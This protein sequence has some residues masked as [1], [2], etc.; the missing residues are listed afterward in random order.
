M[1]RKIFTWQFIYNSLQQHVGVILLYVLESK[2]SSPGRQGF[3]MAVNE[4][5]E[6]SGSIGGGIMEHKFAEM[7]KAKLQQSATVHSLY[8]QVHDKLAA[9]NHS[10][11]ICSGEQT[12]F[13]Y[14]LQQKDSTHISAMI[15]SLQQ[16]QNGTLQLSAE[17]IIFSSNI[18]EDNFYFN[19]KS[20]T[21]F[22]YRE[23]TGCHNQLHI[24]GG[25]HCSLALSQLMSRMDFYVHVYDER[26]GLNTT[27]ENN[28]AHNI[29]LVPG[30]EN[31]Q[32]YIPPGN[33]QYVVIMTVGY[34]TDAVALKSLLQNE[35]AYLGMLGSKNK[36][37]KL[38]D[39]LWNE[40]IDKAML[41]R[42]HAPIGIPIKSQTTEEIAVSIA[43]EI[44]KVKNER[45]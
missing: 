40:V 2:G 22:L 19:K 25:G 15:E 36:M 34:R 12:I 42:I 24:I 31:M 21:E 7:A 37:A 6:I 20:E 45:L 14:S 8:L 1:Q 38:F 29:T 4:H 39:D 13:I 3:F 32:A 30:Y 41:D 33:N 28:F 43:A 5:G 44:I 10:G 27:A 35:F 9:A 23:K 11:M 18:P 17:G 26:S 16:Y